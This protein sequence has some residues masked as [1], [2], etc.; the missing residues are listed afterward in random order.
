MQM[1]LH[2]LFE[3]FAVVIVYLF[4]DW[5]GC[6]ML[7]ILERVGI[8]VLKETGLNSTKITSTRMFYVRSQR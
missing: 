4:V 6:L 5:F 2:W 3:E 1:F 8:L 7:G